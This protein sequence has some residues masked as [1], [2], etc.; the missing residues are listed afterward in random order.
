MTTKQTPS[1]EEDREMG[2]DA[3]RKASKFTL[4]EDFFFFF[5]SDFNDALLCV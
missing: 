3:L 5:L 1:S 4:S 2:L